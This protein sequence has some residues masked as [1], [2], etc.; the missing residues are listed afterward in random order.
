MPPQCIDNKILPDLSDRSATFD[1]AETASMASSASPSSSSKAGV[2]RKEWWHLQYQQQY[3]P[4]SAFE[5]A[6]QWS[7]A[8]GALIG[9]M[10]LNWA[11]KGCQMGLSVIPVPHDPF[12][13]PITLNSDPV[14]GPIFIQLDTRSLQTSPD[15]MLFDEF[16]RTTWEHR[17]FLFREEIAKR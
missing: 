10:V 9:K 15:Q 8:I 14:R 17:T 6:L 5:L 3:E 4:D 11:R 2:D 16:D 1:V 13:L 7:V 12:A